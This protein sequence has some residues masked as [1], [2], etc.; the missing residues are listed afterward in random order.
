M[1]KRNDTPNAAK[2]TGAGKQER[3][4]TV[5]LLPE[6]RPRIPWLRLRG[7]WLAQAGFAPDTRIR[8]RVMKGCLVITPE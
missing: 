2:P 1:T 8:V 4:L 3:F 5:Q 6:P 7:L